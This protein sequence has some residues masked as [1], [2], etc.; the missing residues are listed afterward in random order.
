MGETVVATPSQHLRVLLARAQNPFDV[1]DHAIERLRGAV[2]C[3]VE[4]QGWH[5]RNAPPP[6]ARCSS[7]RHTFLL[8]DGE[9][10]SLWE[11][12]HETGGDTGLPWYELYEHEEPLRLARRRAQHPSGADAGGPDAGGTNLGDH[13]QES[14]RAPRPLPERGTGSGRDTELEPDL[15]GGRG[16]INFLAAAGRS[17]RTRAYRESDS[18]D[19]ARRLVRRAENP[20]RPGE[21][22]LRLL[23]TARG[24]EIVHVPKPHAAPP[25]FQVWCS[26]YEHAFLLADGTEISLYEL[27]H[28]FSGTGR[29]I[30]E[31]YLEEAVADQAARRRARDRG[32][33]L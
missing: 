13:A 22:T 26:V 11:L 27:E 21:E 12:R 30:C 15:H 14:D 3:H 20:D 10:R 29:L 31:V 24:H 6:T 16:F 2:L 32:I 18:P 8:A 7:Y 17:A 4:L 33:D 19:H 9:T 28:D 5:H 1:S 23:S 25:P